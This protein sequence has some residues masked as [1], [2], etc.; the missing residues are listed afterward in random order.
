MFPLKLSEKTDRWNLPEDIR[1]YF[2]GVGGVAMGNVAAALKDAGFD[3]SGSDQGLYSPMKEYLTEHKVPV[4]TP[5]S[6]HNL[7]NPDLVIIGNA[8]SRGNPELEET[9]KRR[10]CYTSLPE[11]LRWT[12]LRNRKNI[13]VSGTHGKTTTTA[14]LA[15]ILHSLEMQPGYMIGGAP[16]DLPD[17]FAPGEGELFVIEG[18]EYDIAYFDKRSKFLQYLPYGVIIN[19]IEFDH[20]D[21]F[22]DLEEILA[23]FR[24]L[25]RLMPD[26][27][28]LVVNGDDPAIKRIINEARCPVTTFGLGKDNRFRGELSRGSLRILC[29]GEP[30]G[31]CRFRLPGKHNLQNALSAAAMLDTLGIERKKILW[32]LSKFT[33]VR[34]RFELAGEFAGGILLFDDSAHHPTAVSSTLQAV[35]EGY[36]DRRLWAIFEP[37]SNTSVT[38][39][40]QKQWVE[41]FAPADIIALA[42]LHRKQKVPENKRL[43]IEQ[44]IYDLKSVGKEAYFWANSTII[45]DELIGRVQPGDIIVVMSNGDFGGLITMLK[46]KLAEDI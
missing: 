20:G 11:F 42:S 33:G 9:L 7:G 45:A 18:D 32:G 14:L 19:N 28:R 24:K 10:L 40:Y 1:L 36:P 6:P 38:D 12:V 37:R 30:W 43:S 4:K 8:L 44:L 41:S 13:V 46:E 15:S 5:Y 25:L 29:E 34:R 3:I 31:E 16:L 27:G 23:S 21:I 39:R 2:L 17:G 35:R 26:N 22:R